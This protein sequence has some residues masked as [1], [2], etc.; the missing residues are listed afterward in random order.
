MIADNMDRLQRERFSGFSDHYDRF[1]LPAPIE[2]IRTILSRYGNVD[3]IVLADVGCGTGLSTF[4]WVPYGRSVYGIEPNE[5]MIG[6]ALAKIDSPNSQLQLLQA[7]S[8]DIRLANDSVDVVTCSQSFHWMKPVE[9]LDE[10]ARILKSG[11]LLAIFDY[12]WPPS[13]GEFLET[14]YEHLVAATSLALRKYQSDARQWPKNGHL[15]QIIKSGLY[16]FAKEIC[17]DEIVEM[18]ADQYIGMMRS[19]GSVQQALKIGIDTYAAELEAI[20]REIDAYMN[21]GPS[22]AIISYRMRIGVR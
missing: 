22:T 17:F 16:Q 15:D 5:E 19:Q 21:D 8:T 6:I 12:D 20:E 9:T 10:F 3:D 4:P 13:I 18:G 1:R 7:E 11:G 14:K 2:K